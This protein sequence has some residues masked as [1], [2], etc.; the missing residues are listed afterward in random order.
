MSLSKVLVIKDEKGMFKVTT[1]KETRLFDKESGKEFARYLVAAC[2]PNVIVPSLENLGLTKIISY[3]PKQ[4]VEAK[5]LLTEGKPK[6]TKKA[7]TNT[8][9][10]EPVAQAD[11]NSELA[12]KNEQLNKQIEMLSDMLA[13][14][15]MGSSEQNDW[16]KDLLK[17]CKDNSVAHIKHNGLEATFFPPSPSIYTAPTEKK[18]QISDEDILFGNFDH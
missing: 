13:Q 14:K 17:Y 8:E 12:D 3:L 15:A 18:A 16:A 1:D 6:K 10:P 2:E 11:I 7:A 9:M 5:L 4:V